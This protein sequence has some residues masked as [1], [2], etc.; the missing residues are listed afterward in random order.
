MNRERFKALE[1]VDEHGCQDTTFASIIDGTLHGPDALMALLR[2]YLDKLEVRQAQSLVFT[3]DGAPWIWERIKTLLADWLIPVYWVLDFYH[4]SEH[5]VA[6]A[7]AN[8]I[9]ALAE[10]RRRKTVL[11]ELN[12]FTRHREHLAYDRLIQQK[13]P[14]GSGAIESAI[15]RVI[16]LRL[17]GVAIF[18]K[19]ET[20]NRMLLLHAWFKAGCWNTLENIAL[21]PTPGLRRM[22]LLFG[23]TPLLGEFCQAVS[24]PDS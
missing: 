5:L 15:R 14:L 20:V 16:N 2:F 6:V 12:D 18:W 19:K 8:A 13:L 9:A 4:A 7:V 3:A 10:G 22:N 21:A 17:K 1:V 23:Y 24:A 11:R